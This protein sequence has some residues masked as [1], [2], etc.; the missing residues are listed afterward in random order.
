MLIDPERMAGDEEWTAAEYHHEMNRLMVLYDHDG[1][2]PAVTR[3][4]LGERAVLRQRAELAEQIVAMRWPWTF[5]CAGIVL[6][7]AFA[8]GFLL[9]TCTGPML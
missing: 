1:G 4:V 8:L 9:E 5:V 2:W 6:A 3:Y 7:V